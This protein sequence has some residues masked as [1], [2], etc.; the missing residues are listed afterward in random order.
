MR[1]SG[2]VS[3]ASSLTTD[4]SS[5]FPQRSDLVKTTTGSAPQSHASTM[6]RAMRS[7]T[8]SSVSRSAPSA[9]TMRT[10][11]MLAAKTC[12]S[13]RFF[14][15]HRSKAH[16]LGSTRNITP[17]SCPGARRTATQS[18]IAGSKSPS[19]L[20]PLAKATECS[21]RNTSAEVTTRG[22]PLSRRTMQPRRTS[23]GS[24]LSSRYS[25]KASSWAF[26]H[27]TS[28]NVGVSLSS[29]I[30][31][32]S[33]RSA[34]SHRHA[35][36]FAGEPRLLEWRFPTFASFRPI[37]LSV[38]VTNPGA[39]CRNPGVLR[40]VGTMPYRHFAIQGKRAAYRSFSMARMMA[41]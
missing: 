23:C 39:P 16:R 34:A 21:A 33:P 41:L 35:G 40:Q 3:F 29:T 5:S 4:A 11:S 32:S 30:S 20:L 18:P 27:E 38:S 37:S 17:I 9:W 15:R 31:G 13:P 7:R 22:N 2:P 28:S 24:S 25:S 12:R 14:P 10:V 36:L 19:R 8:S 6:D 1:T 26:V